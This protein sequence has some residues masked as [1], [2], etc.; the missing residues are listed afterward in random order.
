MPSSARALPPATTVEPISDA[1]P[2]RAIEAPPA[3]ASRPMTGSTRLARRT[4]RRPVSEASTVCRDA[5]IAGTIADSSP[6]TT[7]SRAMAASSSGRK[8]KPPKRLPSC[9]SSTGRSAMVSTTPIAVPTTAAT[10]PMTRPPES[11]M[12]RM[13]RRSPPLAPTRPSWRRERRAPTAK[14]GPASRQISSMAR[15]TTV[16][17]MAISA[18]PPAPRSAR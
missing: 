1:L 10:A 13:W 9:S 12:E 7:A 15:P 3:T 6:V 18:V 16:A 8:S 2:Y 4:P 14:A 17:R 11:T 5:V